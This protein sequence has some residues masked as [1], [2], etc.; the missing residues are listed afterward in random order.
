MF[1]LRSS[2][3][4]KIVLLF[5]ASAVM[6]IL[7]CSLLIL[8][9]VGRHF[10]TVEN[11]MARRDRDN[12]L[13]ILADRQN[14]LQQYCYNEGAWDEM[15][16]YVDNPD[17]SWV[18]ANFTPEESFDIDMA[19]IAD[20]NGKVLTAYDRTGEVQEGSDVGGSALFSRTMTEKTTGGFLLTGKG[21]FLVGAHVVVQTDENGPSRGILVMGH[22]LDEQFERSIGGLSKSKV[23]FYTAGAGPLSSS[24]MTS[25][26]APSEEMDDGRF[27][28]RRP[29]DAV[30]E[31]HS[32]LEGLDGRPAVVMRV[33]SGRAVF[34]ST[35]RRIMFI[36]IPFVAAALLMSG[37]AAWFIGRSILSRVK[38]LTKATHDIINR[39]DL[40]TAVAVTG[41]DELGKL[42]ESFNVMV[43]KLAESERL[44]RQKN[45][46]LRNASEE[47]RQQHSQV[48]F[49][50]K[51]TSVG[52]LAAGVAHEFNN[53]LTSIMGYASIAKTEP[54]YLARLLDVV[55]EQG[56][57]AVA[58]TQGLLMFSRKQTAEKRSFDAA[59][60]VDEVLSMIEQKMQTQNVAVVR[61]YGDV[62]QVVANESQV[63][64]ALLNIISSAR[65]NMPEGGVLKFVLRG[66]GR[67]VSLEI[68]DSGKAMPREHLERIFE[69]FF[70]AGAVANSTKVV[71]S[72]EPGLAVAYY[73]IEQSGGSLKAKSEEGVGTTFAI[74]LPAAASPAEHHSEADAAMRANIS[75]EMS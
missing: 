24:N 51:M 2:M 45:E 38:N 30:I 8:Y 37:A 49:H 26:P 35:T 19:Y 15:C 48:V 9:V 71:N 70:E 41:R 31:T 13:S 33:Q 21:V 14:Q 3:R 66:E 61:D 1:K 57:R 43:E 4:S 74:S 75:S 67:S 47:L 56:R 23:N 22:L 59:A 17:S 5:C 36:S 42:A 28:V 58:I 20:A 32:L 7:L 72:A 27:L 29:N 46:Q 39:H 40:S 44:L 50:E 68:S 10:N 64:H 63:Q 65:D 73:I 60:A 55:L 12:V 18:E 6:P 25:G 69:P 11:E 34:T 62:P 52:Q 16:K 53:I 54:E